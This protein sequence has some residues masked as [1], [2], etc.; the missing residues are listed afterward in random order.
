MNKVSQTTAQKQNYVTIMCDSI[1]IVSVVFFNDYSYLSVCMK[2]K[3]P[4]NHQNYSE[5]HCLS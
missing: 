3:Y 4:E 1:V 2:L 5:I